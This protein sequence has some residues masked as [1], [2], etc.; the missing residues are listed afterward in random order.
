MKESAKDIW[1]QYQ[2]ATAYNASVDLY[3]T[4]K[5][6]E[7]FFIGRQWE[8]VQA[9]GLPTPVFNFLK[10]VVL[11]LTASVVSDNIKLQA[12]PMDD[13]GILPAGVRQDVADTINRQFERLFEDQNIPMRLH[14]MTRN[15]AVDGDGCLYVYFD[16]DKASGQYAG[17]DIRTELIE[18]TR[19]FFGN[20][21]DRAVQSQP[22]ILICSRMLI[23]DARRRAARYGGQSEDIRPDR[24]DIMPDE[25]DS[26]KVTVILKLSRDPETKT[27]RAAESTPDAMIRPEWDTGLSLYPIVW[28]SWDFVPDSYHGQAAVTGL[29]PNQIFVNKLFA[30]AMISLMSTAYPKIIYDRT[31][32]ERWDNRVGA[33]IGVNGGDMGSVAKIMDP[34]AISPQISQFIDAAISYTKEFMGA[35]DAALGSENA[36][37]ATAILYLQRATQTPIELVRQNLYRMVED[38]GRIMI[39]HMAA[40]YGL[41]MAGGALFDFSTLKNTPMSIKLDAGA[42]S[43][44]SEIA[45]VSTLDNLMSAGKIELIDYLERLPNGVIP[46]KQ[47]LIDKLKKE[48]GKG[49]VLTGKI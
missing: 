10:R 34:A 41:R 24:D 25:Y 11:F 20:P 45:A 5:N 38:L 28:G 36:D 21:N 42:S 19:V 32:I 6:N 37:N 18:N 12:S 17:G 27:L 7:N 43:Y 30:M 39:D 26:D 47:E 14:E 9:N 2:K 16:P 46:K 35:T 15:M 4:V 49:P 33:A 29:I 31:R 48:E 13:A 1:A 44:W 3:D 8:G 40:F 22:Y 23:G